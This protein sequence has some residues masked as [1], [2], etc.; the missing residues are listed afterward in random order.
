[1]ANVE[2][3]FVMNADGSER[4]NL[5]RHKSYTDEH[6]TW[7]PDGR[8]IAF[9]SGRDWP[10]RDGA[11]IYVMNAD[12]SGVR[13]LTR[14]EADYEPAW[15][16]DGTRIAFSRWGDIYVLDVQGGRLRR[17]TRT[18]G[19]KDTPAWSPD[20][21]V[22]AF[23]WNAVSDEEYGY[24]WDESEIYVMNPE[25][26]GLRR[27]IP[28]RRGGPDGQTHAAWSPDGRSIAFRAHR[29]NRTEIGDPC[30]SIY[31]VDVDGSKLRKLTRC[32]GEPGW[33][34]SNAANPSWAVA[35]EQPD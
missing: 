10:D 9:A 18:F 35:A 7:S 15:S 26:G 28:R 24:E 4:R 8:R 13:R 3:V 23:R 33:W 1:V 14:G 34:Y 22:I 12:G 16:P 30:E 25:G 11:S 17:L 6:S 20:S 5:T 27:L 19:V 29:I 2:D 32:T 21:S 31:V